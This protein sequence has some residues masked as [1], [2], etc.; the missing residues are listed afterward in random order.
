LTDTTAI[1]NEPAARL[2]TALVASIALHAVVLGFLLTHVDAPPLPEE[3]PVILLP[4]TIEGTG[5]GGGG[6]L[7]GP[8]EPPAGP[9]EPDPAPAA[10]APAV[11]PTVVPKLTV[12]PP[13]KVVKPKKPA[14]PKE[15]PKSADVATAAPSGDSSATG[16]GTAAAGTGTG[17][18]SGG[19]GGG[20][21]TGDGTGGDGSGGARP[22]HGSNPKPPYPIA[23]RRLGQQGVVMLEV[24]VRPDGQAGAVRVRKS[25][26]HPMLDDSAVETV[27]ARW[28]FIPAKRNGEPIEATVTFPIRFQLDQG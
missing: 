12:P 8:P 5:G 22:A 19:G 27:R 15:E 25:S 28:R 3:T 18:G 11:P 7:P 17:T 21:G 14:P 20:A 26:G 24:V 6:P 10:P 13:K 4:L 2:T 1:P 9:P 16:T 23:A